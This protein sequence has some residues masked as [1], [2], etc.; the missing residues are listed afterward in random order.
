MHRKPALLALAGCL[1]I[2]LAWAS[3]SMAAPPRASLAHLKFSGT[4]EEAD[5]KYLGLEKSGAFAFQDIKAPYVLIEIMRTTC[6]HC[7]EQVPALNRLYELVANSSLK[8]KVKIIAVGESNQA[9]ALK[10]FKA[11]NKIPY[12]LVPDP[13][14]K[15]GT[16]L[17]ISGTPTT[18]LVDKS[19]QVLLTEEGTFDNAEALFKKLK[20][21]VK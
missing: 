15:L 6:P 3:W 13:D 20:S 1:T 10:Q 17:N 19:G 2:W 21:I 14:W 4:I 7:V 18:V 5:Q 8:D 16:I 11:A 9:S 12:A